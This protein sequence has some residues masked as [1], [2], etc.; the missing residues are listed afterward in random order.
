M[1]RI[2]FIGTGLSSH[3][4]FPPAPLL[5]GGGSETEAGA[6][7][8]NRSDN[9]PR[10]GRH[11][12]RP[13]LRLLTRPNH[14][15]RGR[16]P[17]RPAYRQLTRFVH[18]RTGRRPRRPFPPDDRHVPFYRNRPRPTTCH[19]RT[20]GSAPTGD[21]GGYAI[22]P[23]L[24]IIATR[25][26]GDGDP[27]GIIWSGPIFRNRCDNAPCRGRHSWRPARNTFGFPEASVTLH[28]LEYP[29]PAGPPL[30]PKKGSRGI[31]LRRFAPPL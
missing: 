9:A 5:R 17:R 4:R 13:A 16:R 26:A 23:T 31:R 3:V 10:R 28:G 7:Y 15:R 21:V 22:Q 1:E 12:W 8:W 6:N 27:Y 11:S 30:F 19:G 24:E 20:H 2:P 18:R 14:R 29:G 25:V